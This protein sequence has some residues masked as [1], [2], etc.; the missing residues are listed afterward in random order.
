MFNILTMINL[1]KS[2]NKQKITVVLTFIIIFTVV[3]CFCK[4]EEFGG[5]LELH[6][7][8]DEINNPKENNFIQEE[9]NEWSIFIFNRIYFVFVTMTTVGYGDIIPKSLRVRVL[10]FIFLIATFFVSLA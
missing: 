1:A 2:I 5:L 10:T 6:K 4:D 9:A 3:L 7:R 8:L